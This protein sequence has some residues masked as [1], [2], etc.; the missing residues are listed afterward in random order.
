MITENSIY[1]NGININYRE[2]G[3]GKPMLLVHGMG[4]S[5][6]WDKVIEPLS[7]KLRV[8]A[9]DLP[10]FGKS[11][12]PKINY[13]IKYYVDFLSDFIKQKQLSEF[14]LAGLSLGGWITAEYVI[15]NPL[16]VEKLILISSAGLK[17]VASNIRYPV[18]FDIVKVIIKNIVFA[19]P[20]F[21]DKFLKG[22]YYDKNMVTEEV[23]QK[24]SQYINSPG[25]K[26]AYTSV[27]KNV[28]TIDKEFEKNLSQIAVPTLIIWGENDPTFPL[29]YAKKF[30]EKISNSN[31]KTIPESGHTVTIEKPKIFCDFII[32]FIK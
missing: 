17:T 26:D 12:K 7:E 14:Y 27:L 8:I 31:L 20:G 22:S 6:V 4:S 28:L 29:Q 32:D 25:A 11:D 3:T 13:T 30:N 15:K 1:L 10:G 16:A 2:C 23:Y 18:V 19:I 24:F 21:L 9:V 5:L